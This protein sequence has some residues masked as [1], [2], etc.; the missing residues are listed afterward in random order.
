MESFPSHPPMVQSLGFHEVWRSV[1][2]PG[3]HRRVQIGDI[4]ND[5]NT[6]VL[7][8]I[9][10]SVS[11]WS[12]LTV[13]ENYGHGLYRVEW[14]SLMQSGVPLAITDIDND[15]NKEIVIAYTV[16]FGGAIGFL[17]CLGEGQFR[18][19]QSNIG[20]TRPPFKVMQID[21]N[22]NGKDELVVLTSNPSL[23][24]DPTIVYVNE[25]ISKGPG[26]G[27]WYMGFNSQL[28]RYQGY[29][30]DMAVG[31]V[32]GEGW[33]EIV[34]AGGSFGYLEPVPVDY[35]WYSG[36][37]NPNTWLTRR[38]HTGLESGTGAVMFVDLDGDSTLEFVSGAPGPIGSGSMY[39]LR[40]VSDTTWQ[41]LWA[42]SSLRNSPLWVNS[43][44]LNGEFVVAGANTWG[45]AGLDTLYSELNA[46]HP[47][48]S[49]MGL[50]RRDSMSIQNFHFLDIDQDA[51]T[52]LVFA[53]LSVSLGDH[54]VDY[55]S[56]TTVVGLPAPSELPDRF[57]LSQNYPNPFNP[58]TAISVRLTAYSQVRLRIYDLL[59]RE[60]KTLIDQTMEAGT[61]TVHWQGTTNEGGDAASGV[62]FCRVIVRGTQGILYTHTIKMLLLR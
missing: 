45:F 32:D 62:Y 18:F 19:Y 20:Y 8:A 31:Q 11:T 52:N 12:R 48:G 44:I 55:E 9:R 13:F 4:D 56:D 50:W 7:Y 51:R 27:G 24:I 41:V 39:A 5:G 53:Q 54:L 29:T 33:L 35:L 42:D 49:K 61:H 25:F 37:P 30:F 15:G 2:N 46:Y 47:A 58:S 34:P 60:V 16:P 17:E 3:P 23:S 6:E 28:A 43:G 26:P 57:E 10:D 40:H 1:R 36:L 38:I 22:R 21:V 14:D 59:G